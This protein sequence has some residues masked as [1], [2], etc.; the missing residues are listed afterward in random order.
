MASFNKVLLMGNLTRDP[1]LK[2]LPSQM[3]VVEFGLAC[4]R[5]FKTAAG[6]DREEVTFV[7][8]SAF[9]KTGELINQYFTKGKPIFIEGRL[10]YDQ[11]EDKNGGGKRSKLAV[12]AENFQFIGGR[13]GGGAGGGGGGGGGY[14]SNA[15]GGGGG[16]GDEYEQRPSRPAPQGRPMPQQN[17][18][19]PQ[20]RPQPQQPPPEQPFGEEQAFKEDDIPF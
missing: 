4:N 3:A 16:G 13:D 8:V 2:Y 10:K 12:V 9:G 20:Q 18:P 15:G 19:A 6:E 14:E 5:R 11:W 17:R 1:Q 7:D